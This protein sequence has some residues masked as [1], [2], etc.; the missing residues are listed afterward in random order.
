VRYPVSKHATP[1]EE[2]RTIMEQHNIKQSNFPVIGSQGVV[3][4]G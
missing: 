3:S 4:S 2:L 1:A